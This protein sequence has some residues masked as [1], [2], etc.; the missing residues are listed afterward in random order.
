[1]YKEKIQIRIYTNY[2]YNTLILKQIIYTK[3]HINKNKNKNSNYTKKIS[4]HNEQ[5]QKRKSTY[6][7]IASA[8]LG[9]SIDWSVRTS[10]N[11]NDHWPIILRLLK[12]QPLESEAPR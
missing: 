11:S 10:Y 3:L 2:Y 4:A 6:V 9:G 1:M 5:R 8:S 12:S 7:C